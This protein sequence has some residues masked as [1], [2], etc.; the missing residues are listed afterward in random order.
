MHT[1]P[2]QNYML[3]GIS[4][5]SNPTGYFGGYDLNLQG[6][7]DI[8]AGYTAD[9]IT[10]DFILAD[11]KHNIT[12]MTGDYRGLCTRLG[13]PGAYSTEMPVENKFTP[14]METPP[15]PVAVGLDFVETA[16][17]ISYLIDVS[18]EN[19]VLVRND[20]T[21]EFHL[22]VIDN[23]RFRC[24]DKASDF[25]MNSFLPK[26]HA[27][28]NKIVTDSYKPAVAT[29]SLIMAGAEA[30]YIYE[31]YFTALTTAIEFV[32]DSKIQ[33]IGD[34][35]AATTAYQEALFVDPKNYTLD[36]QKL[37]YQYGKTMPDTYTTN[38]DFIREKQELDARALG[39]VTGLRYTAL[40][41]AARNS[42]VYS[43][44]IARTLNDL[45]QKSV[46][47]YCTGVGRQVPQMPISM[48]ASFADLCV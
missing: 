11:I 24:P 45:Y 48:F 47:A 10:L 26:K 2:A 33:F 17:S 18:R 21:N 37:R 34:V 13:I 35:D 20:T 29:Y 25:S 38:A 19:T 14:T 40:L 32:T 22:R 5:K 6:L 1:R 7:L 12:H 3:A 43:D 31:H 30:F 28:F 16:G 41:T 9:G 4:G 42:G 36:L 39:D 15:D 44:E 27:T 23:S 46:G 8:I